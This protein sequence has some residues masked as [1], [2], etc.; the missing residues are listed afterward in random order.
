M[1]SAG[2][3][4]LLQVK[5]RCCHSLVIRLLSLT[6]RIEPRLVANVASMTLVAFPQDA[7]FA[8]NPRV[9]VVPDSLAVKIPWSRLSA[10]D[11]THMETEN[12]LRPSRKFVPELSRMQS[13]VPE[14]PSAPLRTPFVVQTG[15]PDNR[16]LWPRP[17]LSR[18]FVP[19][20][21]LNRSEEHTSELQSRLHL[22]CR[23]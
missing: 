5:A 7:V 2:A 15:V 12:A 19:A 3:R 1:N 13:F 11:F 6:W 21:S 23:L 20:P 18:T 14:K 10:T 8:A 4:P 16:P 17:E 22:V 9:G